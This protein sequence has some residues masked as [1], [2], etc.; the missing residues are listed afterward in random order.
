M[1]F[2]EKEAKSC[3]PTHVEDWKIGLEFESHLQI[4][5]K[6]AI[7]VLFIRAILTLKSLLPLIFPVEPSLLNSAY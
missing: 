1:I 4:Q 2:I 6:D 7:R 5:G 3:P